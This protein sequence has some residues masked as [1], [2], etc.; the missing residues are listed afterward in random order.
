[1]KR[2]SANR[3]ARSSDQDGGEGEDPPPDG[4]PEGEEEDLLG[5]EGVQMEGVEEEEA[6]DCA[7]PTDVTLPPTAAS[8]A[9][10]EILKVRRG[11][12]LVYC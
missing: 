8:M 7:N 11:I 1:M 9:A 4:I 12:F 3:A 2:A 6:L 10:L 5:G